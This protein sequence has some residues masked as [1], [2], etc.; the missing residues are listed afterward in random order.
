MRR[1][2]V[3][4][5]NSSWNIVNFRSGLIRALKDADYDPIVVAPTDSASDERLKA[6]AVQHVTV[7]I[8]RAGVNPVADLRLLWTYRLLLKQLRADAFLGY[9]I[10]PNIYGSIAARSLNIA[11]MT[12]RSRASKTS[13][14]RR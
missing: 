12:K 6:L 7:R 11:A 4:A 1:R 13:S 2:I 10:K 3:L 8:D 5:A 14:S 9:T